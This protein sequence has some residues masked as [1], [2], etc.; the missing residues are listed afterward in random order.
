MAK[1]N[2]AM[3]V[4]TRVSGKED[5]RMVEVFELINRQAAS[6]QTARNLDSDYSK[7]TS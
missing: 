5:C 7:T 6:R 2:G 3:A 1:W 4:Y